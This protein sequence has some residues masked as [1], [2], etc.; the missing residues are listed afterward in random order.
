MDE[1]IGGFD[2][3][4]KEEETQIREKQGRI[5]QLLTETSKMISR[6]KNMPGQSAVRE[7]EDE[8]DF[9]GKQLKNS[10]ITAVRLQS[11]LDR[12]QGELEKINSLDNKIT[13]ELQQLDAKMQQ[14]Q[15]DI[16]NKYNHV[17]KAKGDGELAVSQLEQ[18]QK[19]MGEK[20]KTMKQQVMAR[21]LQYDGLK[22]QL[23]DSDVHKNLVAQENKL[24]QIQKS[25]LYLS[26]YCQGKTS[27]SDYSQMQRNVLDIVEQVN[28]HLQKQMQLPYSAGAL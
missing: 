11:E 9:K 10:E 12:R 6:E 3:A 4:K 15:N 14:F 19:A 17:D 26:S 21:K 1:F 24:R 7:M 16:K 22:Q 8:L 23:D 5:V 18:R 27:E 28:V 20:V 2:A 13:S 25:V